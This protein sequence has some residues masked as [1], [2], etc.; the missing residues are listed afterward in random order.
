M[1]EERIKGYIE[2]IFGDKAY[3][4]MK[5][6]KITPE[7]VTESR[8]I[9]SN[10]RCGNYNTSWTCP[11]NTGDIDE[12]IG[13]L[14]SYDNAALV[15]DSFEVES[16]E[17][18]HLNCKISDMQDLCRKV[19]VKARKDDVDLFVMCTGPCNHCKE[20]SFKKGIDCP[21]PEMRI[22]SVSGYGIPV[23]DMLKEIGHESKRDEKRIELFG[24]ILY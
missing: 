15:Y 21:H 7:R 4:D 10:N 22:P 2:E 14:E 17:M 8:K 12:C 23:R 11:P 19:L 16:F 1:S 20:C 3:Y 5:L 6:P 9:C 18:E 13:R 24:L